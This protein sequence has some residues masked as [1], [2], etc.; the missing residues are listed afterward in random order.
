MMSRIALCVRGGDVLG[1]SGAAEA[2]RLGN[3]VAAHRVL[4]VEVGNRARQPQD[5]R[6][7]GH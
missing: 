7:R 5:A 1:G 6:T 4:S 3:G 2:Q